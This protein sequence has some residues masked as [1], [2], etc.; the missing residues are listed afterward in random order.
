MQNKNATTKILKNKIN[1]TNM[2]N[3]YYQANE[4]TCTY[5]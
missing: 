4:I 2:D 3:V 1:G 5:F